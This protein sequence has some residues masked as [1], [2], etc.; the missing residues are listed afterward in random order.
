MGTSIGFQVKC[1][2]LQVQGFRW[3]L[4]GAYKA[5]VGRIGKT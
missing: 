5:Y 4:P 3:E 1:S 2:R